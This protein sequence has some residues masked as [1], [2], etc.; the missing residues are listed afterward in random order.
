MEATTFLPIFK[1]FLC[2]ATN[3]REFRYPYNYY[4]IVVFSLFILEFRLKWKHGGDD[5]TATVLSILEFLLE[6][7]KFLLLERLV[8]IEDGGSQNKRKRRRWTASPPPPGFFDRLLD[9]A[10]KMTH[11]TCCC[12][13]FNQMDPK[14]MKEIKERVELEVV[15][16]RPSLWFHLGREIPQAGVPLIHYHQIVEP[17]SFVMPRL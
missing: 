8:L 14:L 4:V 12:L 15:K 3:V 13:T 6:N 7:K 11:M 16:E 17:V 2:K 1:R 9:F 5:Y 10:S